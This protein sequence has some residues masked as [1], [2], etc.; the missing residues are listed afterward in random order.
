MDILI[1]CGLDL[2]NYWRC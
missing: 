1:M 2:I